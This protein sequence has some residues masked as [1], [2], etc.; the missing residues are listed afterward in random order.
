[1][2]RE[3]NWSEDGVR[4]CYYNEEKKRGIKVWMRFESF[5]RES[6]CVWGSDGEKTKGTDYL[7]KGREMWHYY[8]IQT[9]ML[10]CLLLYSTCFGTHSCRYIFI[11]FTYFFYSLELTYSPCH[12]RSHGDWPTTFHQLLSHPIT[13]I[14]F[15]IFLFIFWKNL[16]AFFIYPGYK[17]FIIRCNVKFY[18]ES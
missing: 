16:I 10:G 9:R 4:E 8:I 17:I 2:T 11:L 5:K 1:M 15:A 6:E 13:T 14:K 7:F 12:Y 3:M 18:R